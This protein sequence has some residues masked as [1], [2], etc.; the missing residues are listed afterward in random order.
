MK[1]LE[2]GT[3]SA[4]FP[5]AV[6]KLRGEPVILTEDGRPVAILFPVENADVETISLSLNPK[7]QAILE[8]SMKSYWQEGGLSSEEVRR[9]LGIETPEK[10]KPTNQRRKRKA[11]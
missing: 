2:I 1:A 8:R 5:G 11:E 10:K 9:H 4:M 7:F 6:R 3:I